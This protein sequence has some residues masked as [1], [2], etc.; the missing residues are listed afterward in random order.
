MFDGGI[1]NDS[2]AP[3]RLRDPRVLAFMRRIT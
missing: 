1:T 2:Y 3:A